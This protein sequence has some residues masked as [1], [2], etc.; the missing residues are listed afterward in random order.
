MSSPI[1][2]ALFEAMD[3]DDLVV[4][5]E[6]LRPLLDARAA[7]APDDLLSAKE[8]AEYIRATNVQR[9]YNLRY[10]G[11]ITPE[12]DGTK[13]LFRRGELDRYLAERAGR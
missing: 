5:A 9:I 13:L 6:R 2:N 4:L 1:V 10:A 8:A 11:E 12:R 7:D 3:D